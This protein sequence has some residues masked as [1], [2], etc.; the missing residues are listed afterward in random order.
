LK[1]AE[2]APF[3]SR[4]QILSFIESCP[5]P[6]GKREIA[7]AF[8]LSS[9]QKIHL[10]KV[11]RDMADDGVL[12]RGRK[13]R[14]GKAR[15]MPEVSVLRI[16]G[17]DQDGEL[18]AS[19]CDGDY[20][21]EA[22]T[23]RMAAGNR[24][25]ET[26]GVGDR[27]LA[28]LELVP[29]DDEEGETYLARTIRRIA[30]SP[31]KVLGIYQKTD[32]LGRLDC[33]DRKRQYDIHI[34]PRFSMGAESGDLVRAELM[35]GRRLGPRQA[36]VVERLEKAE[37]PKLASLI[38]IHDHDIPTTFSADA[39][40]QAKAARKAPSSKRKDLRDIAFVT[41]DG[42]DA[43]DF[44]DAVF[45]KADDSPKNPGGWRLMVA[46]ADV[47]WYVR[48]GDAID[49]DAYDRGNS[50][51]FTDRVVPM[52]PEELSN[53]WC[54]L[55]PF[56]D[57]PCLVVEMA[58]DAE[59]LILSH[60]F[61][62]ALIRSS[63]RLTYEQAQAAI[64][65][66]FDKT[67]KDLFEPVIAPLYAAY[68]ALKKAR[69]KRGV[70]ELD[71]PERQ[72]VLDEKGGIGG[73]EVC[74]RYDSHQL[75]EEFMIAANVAAAIAL[76]HAKQPVMYRIHDEPPLDKMETLRQFLGDLGLKLAKGQKAAPALFNRILAKAQG[77]KNERAINEMILRSQAR[78]EYAPENIGHFGL[79]LRRYCHFTSPIRRYSDLL[80]HRALISGKS[81]GE[82][83]LEEDHKD[84][85][86]IGIH[87]SAVERRATAAERDATDR[88]VSLFMSD[89]IGDIFSGRIS[90]VTRFGLFVTLDETGADGLIP[91][92]SLDD[93]YYRHDKIHN[94]LKG[95]HNGRIYRLGD[96][97]KA[98]LI[99]AN[100]LTGSLILHTQGSTPSSARKKPHK[101][102]RK[103]H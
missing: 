43:R 59:G 52:L 27:V 22:P 54:S 71:L 73:I 9:E 36:K 38:A 30:A 26:L 89:K 97:I 69:K 34:D 91:I 49:Q 50:V 88:L 75:I 16:S 10:K 96:A 99:E 7:R 17:T 28:R 19:V 72:I 70:L 24:G 35:V 66:V 76:E 65:G 48:P 83:G 51:Y 78:A 81:L 94:L 92:A 1:K 102:R 82:G 2:K 12:Q 14:F 56:E 6:P 85:S 60:H 32:T 15:V 44:D 39:R 84:F 79:S 68:E 55:K 45:A 64:D 42:P 77:G 18:L 37:G 20:G 67:T 93:D 8:Q 11:L 58:I 4:D 62:R 21:A 87:L 23:I 74:P 86:Q 25:R 95:R 61:F 31:P 103:K 13:R 46:I 47:S 3:P 53:G 33:I 63:A 57:R 100:S 41:I 101:R 80:V 29:G 98:V 5:K 90:S 40:A